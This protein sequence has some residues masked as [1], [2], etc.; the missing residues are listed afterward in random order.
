LRYSTILFD[1]DGTLVD[2]ISLIVDSFHHTLSIHG[3]PA[4]SDE[5]W[6]RTIGSPL[7]HELRRCAPDDE[8]AAAMLLTYR[9]FYIAQHDR[10]VRAYAGIIEA[11][12]AL[13]A[14]G[15]GIGVVTSK[16]RE[17][18][19]RSIRAAGMT[20]DISVIVAFDDVTHGKPHPE[21][22]YIALERMGAAAANTVFVGDSVHDLCSGRAAGVATAAVTWGAAPRDELATEAPD[23][24]IESPAD[25]VS[26]G[27]G[28]R[29]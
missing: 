24:W 5:H 26:L 8:T 22:V 20:D 19:Y 3:L 23:H 2:S 14:H 25:L 13:R 15:C 4:H 28:P 7:A 27:T 29:A 9:T 1:L 12:R 6:R 10:R 16:V 17:G 11:V 18:A 21:P